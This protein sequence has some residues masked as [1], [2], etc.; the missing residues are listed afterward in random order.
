MTSALFP[1]P[2][3]PSKYRRAR[4]KH[5]WR[6]WSKGT[7]WPI[8]I[9]QPTQ[10]TIGAIMT[11]WNAVLPQETIQD[12]WRPCVKTYHGP[13]H[14]H[15]HTY[16]EMHKP[17]QVSLHIIHHPLSYLKT[18]LHFASGAI[19]STVPITWAAGTMSCFENQQRQLAMHLRQASIA[20]HLCG[21]VE[22]QQLS[23]LTRE[24]HTAWTSLSFL[25]YAVVLVYC[26][27]PIGSSEHADPKWLL[28]VPQVPWCFH[29]FL[30]HLGVTWGFGVGCFVNVRCMCWHARSYATVTLLEWTASVHTWHMSKPETTRRPMAP[31]PS[32]FLVSSTKTFCKKT[33]FEDQRMQTH[34]WENKLKYLDSAIPVTWVGK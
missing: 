7:E 19:F 12:V 30:S 17:F 8:S 1:S 6:P 9:L 5:L 13:Y 29:A 20:G 28:A 3:A 22:V 21:H 16:S 27:V 31:W 26:S 15:N 10:P 11:I 18:Q 23:W 33:A 34:P 14:I 24:K 32:G 2:T 4:C 25:F